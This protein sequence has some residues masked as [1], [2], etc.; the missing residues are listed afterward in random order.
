MQIF[1]YNTDSSCHTAT[2][3][4]TALL[5]ILPNYIVTYVPILIVMIANPIL[6]R[7]STKDMEFLITS[8]L[9]QLTSRERDVMDTIKIKFSLINIVFYLC[10]IPNLINGILL[11]T[12]WFNLPIKGI[13][14]VWYIMV[15]RCTFVLLRVAIKVLFDFFRL[16]QIHCKHCLTV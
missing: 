9:G 11:W 14:I 13:I 16:L 7:S 3:L 10:W 8:S 6:Y 5:R 12:L 1:I 15:R 2:N 4:S